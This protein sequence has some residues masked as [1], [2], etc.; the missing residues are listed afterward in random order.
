MRGKMIPWLDRSTP[1]PDVSE[2]LTDADG[3]PGLL[4]A[5]ADLSP[6]RLLQ[7]YQRGIFPWYSDGQ[8]ILWWSTDPRMVLYTDRFKISP[9]LRKTLRRI[10]KSRTCGGPY[11]VRFDSAFERVVRACAA[12]RQ[13]GAGTWISEDIV[14]GYT[15]LHRTGH[16]HSSELWR[17]GELVG[18]AY[19]VSIGRMFYGESMFA[20]ETDASKVALAYLVHFLKLNGVAMV[21]C[22]Q[23]TGHLASLGATPISRADFLAHLAAAVRLPPIAEWR[24][25]DP[26]ESSA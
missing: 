23:E 13:D 12:P 25:V 3:A 18:G 11:Q 10:Q 5:G 9:S 26:V 19:G 1:F 16:A 2:A 17:D 21:D 4:A 8:P 14:Q 15:G 22:Q 7:A 6:W 24:P 20:R